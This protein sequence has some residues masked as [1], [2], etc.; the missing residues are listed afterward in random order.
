MRVDRVGYL[1][2][3]RTPVRARSGRA[4][5]WILV[6][7]TATG[8][9]AM[10]ILV[11]V[12]PLVGADFGVSRGTIQLAIT[13]Y[14]FGIAGGQLLYG[15]VSDKFGR[16]PTLL[17]SLGLYVVASA[18]AGW[19]AGIG[20]LLIARVGQAVGGCGGLVLGRA[21]VRD[22]AGAGQAASRMA[23][24]TMVQSLAP[25]IGPAVGGFL[26]AWFGWRSIFVALVVFGV[27]TLGGVWL[28]LPETAA[29]RGIAG[30]GRMLG[31]YLALLRSRSFRGYMFGG[32]FTSTS[33]YAY[34]TASP[35]IFT[36]MLHRPATEVGL[37]Y[38]V[39]MSGVPIGSFAVSRLAPLV[40]LTLLLRATSAIAVL[41]ALL[42]FVAAASS[43]INLATVL[44]PMILFSIGV[45]A[46]GPVAITTAIS[47]DPQMI[48]AAS[49]LYG[50]MQMANGALCTLAVGFFPA[51][52]ALSAAS[53]LLAG[54]LLGQY[55]FL[56][57]TRTRSGAGG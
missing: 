26:G 44:L 34:L 45:G 1:G 30:S 35:F 15:P 25:G 2:W 40:R 48:G 51:N 47:T 43:M 37:Y 16:R 41:G 56:C 17:V 49:G 54:I 10:H 38:L 29:S 57:A 53:V 20:T 4:P 23:L 12:L 18:V 21:I 27:V 28:A 19:A 31:S 42:F 33:F 50:F 3:L 14:L 32:A 13:L 52:P 9:L 8:T 5:F 55:F 39:V 6:A 7:V 24:L 46:S 22:G 11:P 36:Q